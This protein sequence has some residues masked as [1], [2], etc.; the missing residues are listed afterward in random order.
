[1]Q[2][3]SSAAFECYARNRQNVRGQ[4][5]V[6]SARSNDRMVGPKGFDLLGGHLNPASNQ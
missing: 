3:F 2:C 1:M 5:A 6:A 4:L